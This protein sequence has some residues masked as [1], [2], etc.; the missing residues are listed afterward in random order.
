MK[1]SELLVSTMTVGTYLSNSIC[2][3]DIAKYL[4]L[5]E[6]IVGIKLVYAGGKSRILRGV[7][8]QTAKKKRDFLNQVTIW[9]SG[10]TEGILSCKLFRNGNLHI[11]GLK[12]TSQADTVRDLLKMKLKKLHGSF[13]IEMTDSLLYSSGGDVIGYHVSDLIFYLD[14]ENCLVEKE[15]L[16]FIDVSY[17]NKKKKIY[18]LAGDRIGTRDLVLYPNCPKR[19]TSVQFGYVYFNKEIVGKEET[20]FTSP[21]QEYHAPVTHTILP[22]E[23]IER[24]LV[25]YLINS[26]FQ[27]GTTINRQK[28]HDL[29][30]ANSWDSRFDISSG[31]SIRLKVENTTARFF[32][33]GKVLM[34]STNLKSPKD[35]FDL[36]LL[37][38]TTLETNGTL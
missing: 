11:T 2:I 28:L 6:N 4:E 7:V 20:T 8:K 29:F 32:A 3:T 14:K 36:L 15:S 31:P 27:L 16:F 24:P 22:I 18:S 12:N 25:V 9:I 38:F 10:V 33:S 17:K 23:V 5:D 37:Y 21:V 13:P 35:T 30:L 1:F 34:S 26:Y 19:F